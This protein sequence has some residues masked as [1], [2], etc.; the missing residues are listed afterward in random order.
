MAAGYYDNHGY[1]GIYTGISNEGLMPLDNILWGTVN[2]N[3]EIRN[4]CPLSATMMGLD[5]RQSYGH[6]DDF[7]YQYHHYGPDP[8][9]S[10]NR[11]RH[12]DED[13]T[14]DFMGSNQSAFSNADGN[15]R[16]FFLP[17]GALYM[18]IPG[19]SRINGMVVMACACS[20][21]QKNVYSSKT[22]HNW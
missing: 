7:W 5:E 17:D 18:T 19:M 21:S 15:T 1:P 16:F 10:L 2:I 14:G 20:M 12:A 22:L 13:C 4:Q 9:I 3:G 8:Y 11:N 6:V